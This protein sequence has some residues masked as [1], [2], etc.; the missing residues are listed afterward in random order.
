[1][2]QVSVHVGRDVEAWGAK[3]VVATGWMVI[4]VDGRLVENTAM[5][6]FNVGS[7]DTAELLAPRVGGFKLRL[8]TRMK[9]GLR[10]DGLPDPSGH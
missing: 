9:L 2:T 10:R 4:G 8:V 1:M 7:R 6:R 3:P 5:I